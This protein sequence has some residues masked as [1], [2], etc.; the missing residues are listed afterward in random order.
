V[1]DL[2]WLPS[3]FIPANVLASA[4]TRVHASL[5]PGGFVLFPA[6]GSAGQN[7]QQR[8]MLALMNEL[9][10]G[11]LIGTFEAETL[12]QQAGFSNVRTL[13]APPGAPGMVVGQ[14]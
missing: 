6:L 3:F 7:A 1:F 8:A 13:P 4:A 2:A 9:W 10:G 5:R 11:P 14:R 12:L